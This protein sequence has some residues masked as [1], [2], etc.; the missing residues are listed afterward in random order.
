MEVVKFLATTGGHL[1]PRPMCIQQVSSPL[2]YRA[3]ESQNYSL[4]TLKS[5]T[6]SVFADLLFY[7]VIVV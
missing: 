4:S 3:C 6:P 5:K 1:N 7:W 2:P